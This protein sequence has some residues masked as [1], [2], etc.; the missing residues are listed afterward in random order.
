[1]TTCG[2][3]RKTTPRIEKEVLQLGQER[4]EG[5]RGGLRTQF[6]YTEKKGKTSECSV[7]K[8]REREKL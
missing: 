5:E 1:M 6:P 8:R 3:S 4:T 7:S 2:K